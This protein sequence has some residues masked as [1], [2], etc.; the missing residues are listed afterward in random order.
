VIKGD[1][2]HGKLHGNAEIIDKTGKVT[3]GVWADGNMV[4]QTYD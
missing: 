1:W 3:K 2:Q 4:Q